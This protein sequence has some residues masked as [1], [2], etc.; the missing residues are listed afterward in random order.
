[1]GPQ[2]FLPPEDLDMAKNQVKMTAES[3]W[4]SYKT[5]FQIFHFKI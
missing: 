3:Y 1:M 4:S 2:V 5:P